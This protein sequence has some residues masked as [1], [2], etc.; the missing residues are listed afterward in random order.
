MNTAYLRYQDA[1]ADRAGRRDTLASSQILDNF[2]KQVQVRA[3]RMARFATGN[4]DDALDV[5]QDTMFKL[6]EKYS[7]RAEDELRPLFFRILQS[8]IMDYHRRNGVRNKFKGWL[9][10]YSNDDEVEEDPFQTVEDPRGR[11]PEQE[12]QT[13]LA[14]EELEE[15]LAALPPRQQQAFLLRAW[16]GLDVRETAAAMSCAE[17]SVKTHYSR[18]VHSLRESLGAHW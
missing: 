9:S 15:A 6:V 11:A 5:V 2:L 16:E 17:G 10:S 18:A 3:F 13:G 14:I 12:L 8:R 1:T 7:D 4:N